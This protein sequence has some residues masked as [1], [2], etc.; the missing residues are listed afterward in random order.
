MNDIIQILRQELGASETAGA[1]LAMEIA[2]SQE[3]LQV[4]TDKIE[5]IKRLISTCETEEKIAS[6]AL[7]QKTLPFQSG[8]TGPN[9]PPLVR[10]L[11]GASDPLDGPT[12]WW[13]VHTK[14]AESEAPVADR[15]NTKKSKLLRE[16][17]NILSLRGTVHR[18]Q[19]LDHLIEKGIMGHEA[20]PLD[21]LGIFLSTHKDRFMSVGD[22]N[23][24]L[25]SAPTISDLSAPT[26][27]LADGPV[28]KPMEIEEQIDTKEELAL[29]PDS[30]AM[31]S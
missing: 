9:A 23:F 31:T 25:R 3:R 7:S 5:Q 1:R 14:P 2:R 20:K 13:F 28:S 29:R 16:I 24:R 15:Q 8:P 6:D 4:I 26:D 18:R 10:G 22:G 12:K 27:Y 30:P 17:T 19:I 11:V 21:A